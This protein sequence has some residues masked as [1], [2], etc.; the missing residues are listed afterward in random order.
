MQQKDISTPSKNKVF[1]SNELIEAHYKQEY[2]VQEQRTILWII[3]EIHRK[4]Y[5][6]K[7]ANKYCEPSLAVRITAKDYAKLMNIPVKNV[8]RDAQK[9][10][11]N[12]MEKVIKIEN[13]NG[14]KMFHWVSSMEYINQE[15]VIEATLANDIV[16]YI[17]DL[18]RYTEF[19]LE[20]ILYINSSHAIKIYQLL[21]QYK[22]SGERTISVTDLR[23]ILGISTLKT[24][25][26]YGAI[27]QRI[28]EIS[29]REINEKTDLSISYSEIKKGRKVEAIKFKITQK[30]TQETKA[31]ETVST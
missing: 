28:L 20:N 31:G 2:S 30:K 26:W 12:L 3:S 25:E 10:S 17:I 29:K 4:N 22:T 11:K 23:Y 8:Y 6:A 5:F 13:K 24:Y 7:R 14:W 27:K 16:P 1:Q 9:I 21:A 15:A 19:K 18:E